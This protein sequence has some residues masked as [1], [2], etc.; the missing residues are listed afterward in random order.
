M[1]QDKTVTIRWHKSSNVVI[2]VAMITAMEGRESFCSFVR[3]MLAS[4]G[5]EVTI[6]STTANLNSDECS[7][8]G[9]LPL[10]C[11]SNGV[12]RIFHPFVGLIQPVKIG[13]PLS[14]DDQ[15]TL[16]SEPLK[17]QYTT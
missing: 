11:K 7:N 12:E 3:F 4:S 5:Y 17:K 16:P 13:T 9:S 2:I 14:N 6:D 10:H 1:H 8:S 15:L